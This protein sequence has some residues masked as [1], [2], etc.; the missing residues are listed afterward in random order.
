MFLHP[1]VTAIDSPFLSSKNTGLGNVL[2]QI[3][4]V[5]GL[6]KKYNRI[7]NFSKVIEFGKLLQERYGFTHLNT[8]FRNCYLFTFPYQSTTHINEHAHKTLSSH[9]LSALE[10]SRDDITLNGYL[11]SPN[12]FLPYTTEIRNLLSPDI[13]SYREIQWKYPELFD[14]TKTPVSIHVRKG[15]D[16]NTGCSMN[17]YPLA[18]QYIQERVS[19]PYFFVVSDGEVEDLGVPATYVKG[20]E[21]YIDLWIC[22]LCTHNITTYST[23]SW[24]GAF[25]NSNPLKIVTYP[26]SAAQFIS[27]WNG[28]PVDVLRDD[29]FL[30]A[31]CIKDTE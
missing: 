24:W 9:I 6:S 4:S 7:P 22:S 29:Y 14:P 3:A 17:Y 10:T 12:Y 20:N 15:G 2:F 16:R 8:I 5:Y 13:L 1:L 27:G 30:S 18:I 26:L 31:V 25:L 19:N 21:D 11:E 28:V 23:F